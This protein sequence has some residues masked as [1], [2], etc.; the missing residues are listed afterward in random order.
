MSIVYPDG[1][2][3]AS[4]FF[5]AFR[6]ASGD[7]E[8]ERPVA[9][10]RRPS[11]RRLLSLTLALLVLALA[12]A[13]PAPAAPLPSRPQDRD[14]VTFTTSLGVIKVRLFADR[15][16]LTVENFLRYVDDRFYDDTVFHRVIANFVVQGGG[17]DPDLRLKPMR[18]A[19]RNESA[20][21]LS[22]RRGTLALARAAD[23]DSGQ[24]QF[25]FNLKDNPFLDGQQ[26]APGQQPG[27]AGYCVFGEVVEG[28]DVL[29]R[30]SRV[31]TGERQG[32]QDVPQQPV[33]LE[34]VRRGR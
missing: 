5:V 23:P 1:R 30:I 20:N 26:A 13:G 15:A 7:D 17:F 24:A 6:A 14:H 18:P 31:A 12:I 25:Y 34:K 10:D 3:V 33:V 11:M 21:G 22:N 19:V 2:V 4:G 32:M 16:P 28:M 8:D 9:S 27:R 29:D